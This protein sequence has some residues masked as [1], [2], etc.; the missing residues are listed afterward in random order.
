LLATTGMI[1]GLVGAGS[2]RLRARR[3]LRLDTPCEISPIRV[4]SLTGYAVW[5]ACGFAIGDL[6]LILVDAA[7]FGAMLLVRTTLALRRRRPCPNIPRG[8]QLV[9]T[10][11]ES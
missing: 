7:G 8:K 3:L 6:P 11:G 5:L 2:L 9:G 10:A 4:V 1:F